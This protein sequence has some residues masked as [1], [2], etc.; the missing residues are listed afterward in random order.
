M[1]EHWG[2]LRDVLVGL[3]AWIAIAAPIVAAGISPVLAALAASV[4][5][6]DVAYCNRLSGRDSVA[7]CG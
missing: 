3:V 6:F 7:S 4:V 1:S 5:G 2:S